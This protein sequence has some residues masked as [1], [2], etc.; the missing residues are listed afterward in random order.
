[1]RANLILCIA[2]GV[3]VAHLAVFM[4]YVRLTFHPVAEPPTPKPTFKV[5]EEIV[6]VRSGG[7]IV[8]REFTITTKLAPPGTYKGRG[9]KPVNE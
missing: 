7:R 4:I 5:A 9:G 8:N 6:P 1:M 2:M 3:F